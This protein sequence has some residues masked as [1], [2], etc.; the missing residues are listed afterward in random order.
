MQLDVPLPRWPGVLAVIAALGLGLSGAR[1]SEAAESTVVTRISCAPEVA[2]DDAREPKERMYDYR[3]F[4][5]VAFGGG[6][7]LRCFPAGDYAPDL[8]LQGARERLVHALQVV[9][10]TPAAPPRF[11]ALWQRAPDAD[12]S[13]MDVTRAAIELTGCIRPATDARWV[14]R[15]TVRAWY[16]RPGM[17]R[18]SLYSELTVLATT[19]AD[20]SSDRYPFVETLALD[21]VPARGKPPLDTAMVFP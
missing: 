18:E 17:S 5:E 4:L 6:R 20:L 10:A 8:V 11:L 21:Q 13:P 16:F 19:A 14:C 2:E 1:V 9:G 12:I 15:A 3:R 7:E